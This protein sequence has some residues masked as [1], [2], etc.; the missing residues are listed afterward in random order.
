MVMIQDSSSSQ[1]RE[2]RPYGQTQTTPKFVF[3]KLHI[4]H[5]MKAIAA[6]GMVVILLLVGLLYLKFKK[7]MFVLLV[8]TT[9]SVLTVIAIVSKRHRF[10]WPVVAISMFHVILSCYALLIFSFYFFFKPFYILM[11]SN[12]MFDTMHNDKNAA[13]YLQSLAMYTFLTVFMLF[14]AWQAHVGIHF[15]EH[16]HAE[17]EDDDSEPRQIHQPTIV[18]VNK[19]MY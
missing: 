5:T 8:P 19:P 15:I 16:I 11:I 9:V 17:R 1:M 18:T 3:G 4:N 7:A 13:F 14:N 12:W 10:V 6:I 2:K